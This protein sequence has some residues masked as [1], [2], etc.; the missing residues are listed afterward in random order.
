MGA[1]II[2]NERVRFFWDIRFP[3]F[4][5]V[6]IRNTC[7]AKIYESTVHYLVYR[8]QTFFD[9]CRFGRY[10]FPLQVSS[11]QQISMPCVACNP[12]I[13]AKNGSKSKRKEYTVPRS[14]FANVHFM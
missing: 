12:A 10:I 7:F 14:A 5:R 2:K 4:I 13:L 11:P 1:C 8:L 9:V 6:Q 3:L